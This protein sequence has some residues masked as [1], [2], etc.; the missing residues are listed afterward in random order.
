MVQ[1]QITSET[2]VPEEEKNVDKDEKES[3][4]GKTGWCV[5][6]GIAGGA[7]IVGGGLLMILTGPVGLV[8]GG[9]ILSTGISGEINTI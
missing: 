5:I 7:A 4:I 2:S 3:F 8:V 6:T 1:Y 9:V